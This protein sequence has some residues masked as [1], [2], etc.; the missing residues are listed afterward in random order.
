VRFVFW[1]VVGVLGVLLWL[2]FGTQGLCPSCG[3][4]LAASTFDRFHEFETGRMNHCRHCGW[5][6]RTR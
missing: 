4:E 6:R 1:I 2:V 3:C 5:T